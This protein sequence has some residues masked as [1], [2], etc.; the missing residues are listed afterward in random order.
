MLLR[1][2]SQGHNLC[3]LV[4]LL[5]ESCMY[6]KTMV[7]REG[8]SMTIFTR[9]LMAAGAAVAFTFP[10]TAQTLEMPILYGRLFEKGLTYRLNSWASSV[11]GDAV[12]LFNLYTGARE[13]RDGVDTVV[14]VTR[15]VANDSLYFELK[16][17]QPGLHRIGDCVA[18]RKLDHAIYEGYLAGLERW[19][20]DER[21]IV[22]GE[23]ERWPDELVGANV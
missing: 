19:D 23:L 13:R 17:T 8:F 9:G 14:V 22:E 7:L 20:P 12:E 11:E 18:P 4:G 16:G 21:Y 6:N 3:F 10:A 5:L 2:P 15:P 1:N